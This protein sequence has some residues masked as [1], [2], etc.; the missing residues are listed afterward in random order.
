LWIDSQG[1]IYSGIHSA[2]E[3]LEPRR[4]VFGIPALP[5]PIWFPAAA[6]FGL[7]LIAWSLHVL[8]AAMSKRGLF[9]GVSP[10]EQ[11]ASSHEG[12]SI[13]RSYRRWNAALVAIPLAA[14]F[15]DIWIRS[16]WLLLLGVVYFW[17]IA[18]VTYHY[19]MRGWMLRMT[20]AH[21]PAAE[22]L[23]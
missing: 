19:V 10:A 5:L 15:A 23:T 18:T 3:L 22:D 2:Y 6:F 12:R 7:A 9:F 11:F 14:A 17:G 1:R 16:G 20:A 13:L 21:A 4:M 8:P